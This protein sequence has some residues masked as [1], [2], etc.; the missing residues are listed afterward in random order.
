MMRNAANASGVIGFNVNVANI[1]AA[2]FIATGQD[3]ACIS[4]SAVCQLYIAP[5][6]KDEIQSQGC[7]NFIHV[8][9]TINNC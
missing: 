3:V 4:E 1:L 5:A 8:L 2:V 6:R 7:F 9:T